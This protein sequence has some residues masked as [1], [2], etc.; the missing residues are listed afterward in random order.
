MELIKIVNMLE[1]FEP[2]VLARVELPVYIQ[3]HKRM[4]SGQTQF[5]SNCL[6]VGF[7]SDLPEVLKEDSVISLICVEDIP[8]SRAYD[9]NDLLNLAVV[10]NHV[11]PHDILNKIADIMIDEARIVSSMQILLDALYANKGLQY[12]VDVAFEVFENPIFIN[13]TAYKILAM[14]SNVSFEDSTLEEE[15]LLGYIHEKNLSDMRNDKVFKQLSQSIYPLYSK[16]KD[17]TTGWLFKIIAIHGVEVGIVALVETNRPFRKYDFELL[18][19]FSKLISIELE[20]NDFYKMNKGLMYS[21]F[22]A[23]LISD[24]L[25]KSKLVEQRLAYLHMKLYSYFQILFITHMDGSIQEQK[26]NRIAHEI[27]N[28]VPDCRW[29]VYQSNLVVFINRPNKNLLTGEEQTRLQEFLDL[30]KL[31]AGIS[32]VFLDI[33]GTSM[34]YRQSMRAAELGLYINHK[35]GLYYYS[36]YIMTYIAKILSKRHDIH[37]FCPPAIEIIQEYDASYHTNLLETLE[38][39]LYY[40]ENP[41]AASKALHIHRNTLIYRINKI[42]ELTEIDLG[43]G[44]VRLN[45]QL[46]LKFMMYQ[47][48]SWDSDEQLE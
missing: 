13:D 23:D 19:R 6:Y 39:Y 37:E 7:V 25:Y 21:Y 42:K 48:G 2:K 15:K 29:T 4:I 38:K 41:V 17:Q 43:N 3:T 12:L 1:E 34:H 9:K 27:R 20:K 45:I 32:N 28:I 30:N 24:K 46:Y 5:Y 35:P 31:S 22:L 40:P 14:S 47:K 44:D 8:L 36:D 16:R 11:H 26:I 33:M 18:E 10:G